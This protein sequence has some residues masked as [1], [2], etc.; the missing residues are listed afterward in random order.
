[1]KSYP[2][3]ETSRFAIAILGTAL[4]L[5]GC[6]RAAAPGNT[7]AP[8]A[9]LAG[10]NDLGSQT[11]AASPCLTFAPTGTPT[12][13]KNTGGNQAENDCA[14][15][16]AFIALNWQADPGDPGHPAKT[17]TWASFGTPG[18]MSPKVWET[19]LEAGAVFGGAAPLKGLWQAKR[20]AVKSLSRTSKFG[21]IDLSSIVQAGSGDHWLTNQRG[22]VT[23]YEIMMNR[24]EFEFITT[25]TGFD[26]TTAAGQLACAQQPGKVVYD[27]TP[28]PPPSLPKRGGM[29]M[30]SGNAN[31]WSDTDCTGAQRHWG[32]GVGAME[33]KAAWTPLPADHS[34]DYRYKTAIA[35]VRDPT[36]KKVRQVTVGLVGL[37]ILRKTIGRQQWVW[38]T[39]EQ[40]DNSPDE[41]AN[42]GFSPP[43]LPANP[44]RRPPPGYTFFNPTCTPAK[45]PTYQCQ[46]N[47]P[48]KP[49]GTSAIVC[50]PYDKPMQI[51]RIN[52]VADPANQVT[53]YVWGLLPAK[54][55]FN[56][57][58][59]INVQ[60]PQQVT[61]LEPA[62]QR[63]PAPMGN[64]TP[65][66]GAG[67]LTQIVAN[68]T[69][70]SFQQNSNS[71]MDCHANFASIASSGLLHATAPGALRV[72]TKPNGKQGLPP[73][74]SDY[75]FIFLAET[76]K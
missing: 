57:Y 46:H 54:S 56:Y 67:G 11:A 69:L 53:A 60:W 61:L 71:C 43:A 52:P 49:C 44:N 51:T 30:P 63:L 58:R 50:D 28:P 21:D 59:L 29:S 25:Q 47:R 72:V 27:G 1:M 40:I 5:A 6:Q 41:A 18:D 38:S 31:G 8:E 73:Y 48:P 76:K 14:A 2:R 45:D 62:G 4:A 32:D 33:I 15:W 66:G 17:A 3:H 26:L 10:G 13:P 16:Q 42:G 39:F 68:T 23:Y 24:D 34:L 74:A 19:Y 9:N 22:D 7:M 75:S 55:V 65:K 35:E 20:P 70:E 64:Q 36:T 37:H 12:L